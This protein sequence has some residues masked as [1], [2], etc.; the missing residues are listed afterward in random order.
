MFQFNTEITDKV[1]I[2]MAQ[3]REGTSGATVI[4]FPYGAR[5]GVDISGGGP[6]SR[7]SPL[8][9]P[10][11]ADNPINAIAL[12]GGSS[13]GLAVSTG[14]MQCLEEQG[15]GLPTV[16]GLVPLVLQ[17]CIYD[18]HRC[19]KNRPD[20]DV[21]YRACRNALREDWIE[22]SQG[23]DAAPE[24]GHC[25]EERMSDDSVSRMLGAFCGS[26]GGGTG[27]MVGKLHGLERADKSGQGAAYL[28]AGKLWILA[29][30][31]VNAFGDIYDPST[32]RQIAGL[33]TEDGRNYLSSSEEIIRQMAESAVPDRNRL[34]WEDAAG[35]LQACGSGPRENT[36]IGVIVTNAALSKAEACKISSMTRNAYARCIHPV[37]TNIDG[38]SIYTAS[39]GDMHTDISFLGVLT[40]EAM[41]RAILRSV[42]KKKK[43]NNCSEPGGSEQLRKESV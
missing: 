22:N 16:G 37:S 18:L 40:C 20:A 25:N 24:T 41:Q 17:S 26:V 36:T 30:V 14:I 35:N 21:G 1:R 42:E 15:V 28:R 34:R 27:A 6:A 11:T 12:S 9:R 2:G 33:H 38:D 3:N 39:V 32:G 23:A 4:Y 7:E 8:A 29:V 13:Y 19:G 31:V 43:E 10:E 5:V